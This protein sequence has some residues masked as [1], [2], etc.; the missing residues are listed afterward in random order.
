MK[1][2]YLYL[3]SPLFQAQ[4]DRCD[5]RNRQNLDLNNHSDYT[6]KFS[7]NDSINMLEFLIDNTFV[8]FGGRV[9]QQKVGIPMG[10]SFSPF[11]AQLDRCDQRNRQNLDLFSE[12]KLSI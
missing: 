8:I 1:Q 10:T 9:F 4:L 6:K 5:Q 12:K 7:E 3:W 2:T 11:Q